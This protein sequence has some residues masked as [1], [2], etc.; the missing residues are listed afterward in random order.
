MDSF[1]M[2]IMSVP[3]Q[4]G[5]RDNPIIFFATDLSFTESFDPGLCNWREKWKAQPGFR[6]KEP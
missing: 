1:Y 5:P 4:L 3:T 6:E 2:K